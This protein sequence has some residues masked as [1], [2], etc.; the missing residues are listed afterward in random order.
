[1]N[2]EEVEELIGVYAVGA[3]DR[4]EQIDVRDH[5]ASCANHPDAV[6]LQVV[7]TSLAFA[8]S[9]EQPTP[10]LKTRLLDAV[11]AETGASTRTQ[12]VGLLGWLGRLKPQIA[13][14]YAVAGALAVVVAALL[15]T[16]DG[17]SDTPTTVTLTGSGDARAVVRQLEDG[18]VVMEADGLEPLPADQTYQVWGITDQGPQSLGLLGPAPEGEALG[19]MRGDLSEVN[20]VAVTIEPAEGSTAPTTDPVLSAETS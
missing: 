3:L 2:C 9:D 7:A 4:A 17:A 16:N 13:I 8:V 11:R 18:L 12:R 15:L 14:P 1:M 19:A 5:L 10:R 6:D 20:A